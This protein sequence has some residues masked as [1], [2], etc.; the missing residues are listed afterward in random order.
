M[1]DKPRAFAKLCQQHPRLLQLNSRAQKLTQLD[2]LLQAILPSNFAGRC[3]LVNRDGDEATI[4]AENAAIASL[5]RFQSRK[6]CQ[7]L[8][9]QLTEPVKKVNVKVRPEHQ[10]QPAR[11]RLKHQLALSQDS[12]QIIEQTAEGISD[13]NL[14]AALQRLAKRSNK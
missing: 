14:R 10:L 8:S 4:I 9:T 5:L 2:S 11:P 12:A 6:I 7:Q 3:R 1:S 13:L